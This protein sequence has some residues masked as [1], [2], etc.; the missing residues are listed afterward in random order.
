MSLNVISPTV[1]CSLF[2][3]LFTCICASP[4]KFDSIKNSPNELVNPCATISV[5]PTP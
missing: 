5:L 4:A 2:K 3:P 1:N